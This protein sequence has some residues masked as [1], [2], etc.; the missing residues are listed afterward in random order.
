MR[1]PILGGSL[2]PTLSASGR[3]EAVE[4]R[5]GDVGE[6]V[7]LFVGEAIEDQVPDAPA[8]G[9]Y[10]RLERGAALGGDGDVDGPTVA[11]EALDEAAAAH[12]GQLVVEAALLPRETPAELVGALLA[13][14]HL[15]E[16]DEHGV[17]GVREAAV[18]LEVLFE[19]ARSSS[20]IS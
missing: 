19:L 4:D 20:C 8:V 10:R 5:A 18:G 9:R 13:L 7:D 2:R 14:R 15:G 12:P 17:V 3:V 6:L 1:S 11:V 16:H